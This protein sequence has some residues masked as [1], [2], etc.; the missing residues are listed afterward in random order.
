MVNNIR[1]V[2]YNMELANNAGTKIIEEEA[3]VTSFRK[4]DVLKRYN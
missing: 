3:Y 2:R 4:G 1:N